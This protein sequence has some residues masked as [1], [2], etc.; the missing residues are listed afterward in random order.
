MSDITQE[1]P[2]S[3][4][5]L[6]TV[7]VDFS[8]LRKKLLIFCSDAHAYNIAVVNGDV[9]RTGPPKPQ[10]LKLHI[11]PA[12]SYETDPFQFE[13]QSTAFDECQI[14]FALL[15]CSTEST[16][17][18]SRLLD[19]KPSQEGCEHYFY[20]LVV[21]PILHAGSIGSNNV[22]QAVCLI[23]DDGTLSNGARAREAVRQLLRHAS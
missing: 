14:G 18:L 12:G 9:F 21:E 10:T 3:E 4:I 13:V 15:S 6:S 20:A 16:K 11:G 8:E 19:R 2:D 17:Q 23:E 22:V 7:M 5:L 1:P